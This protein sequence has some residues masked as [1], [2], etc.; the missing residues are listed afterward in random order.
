MQGLSLSQCNDD[1]L[2][3]DDTKAKKPG[4][5]GAPGRRTTMRKWS[6]GE[7]LKSWAMMCVAAETMGRP[8]SMPKQLRTQ[9]TVSEE[10]TMKT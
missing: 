7:P 9:L 4:S 6:C 5:A 2:A 10:S 3:K 1:S 8:N